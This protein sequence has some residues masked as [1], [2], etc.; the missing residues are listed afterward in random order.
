MSE[1][2]VDFTGKFSKPIKNI[3]T[4]LEEFQ[5]K[6]GIEIGAVNYD[7]LDYPTIHI[8]P[9]RTDYQGS[10]EYASYVPIFF[11]FTKGKNEN[12]YVEHLEDVEKTIDTILG[13][14]Q[15]NDDLFEYKLNGLENF[16]GEQNNTLLEIIKIEIK[17]SRI[18]DVST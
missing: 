14:L 4:A 10:G 7:R 6:Y 17:V 11:Y 16:A 13:E 8:I 3:E 5:P 9:D 1:T 15:E 18:V 2:M 12:K